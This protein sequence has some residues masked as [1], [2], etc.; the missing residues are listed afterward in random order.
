MRSCP[1]EHRVR[2]GSPLDFSPEHAGLRW[3]NRVSDWGLL[4]IHELA[5]RGGWAR[6]A[7]PEGDLSL[8]L[9][10]ALGD[11]KTLV[12]GSGA[13]VGSGDDLPE[14]P[15]VSGCSRGG[16]RIFSRSA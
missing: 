4:G 15:E 8:S 2:R 6:A 16:G 12:Q 9:C 3:V 13:L 7:P 10:D 14:G 1:G 11:A 5:L